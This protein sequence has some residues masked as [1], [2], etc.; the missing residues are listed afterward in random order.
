MTGAEVVNAWFTPFHYF[1]YLGTLAVVL[2]AYLQWKWSRTCDKNI[3][4]VIVKEAGGTETLLVPKQGGSV[5]IDNPYTG[6]PRLWA[7]S[8][9]ATIPMP[10][11]G[12]G[13]LPRFLLKT[14]QQAIFLEGDWEPL[15]NRSPHR[16]K[17]VSPDV[18]K[19]LLDIKEHATGETA[20]AIEA[21]LDGISTAPTREMIASPAMLGNLIHEKISALVITVTKDFTDPIYEAIKKMGR[22]IDPRIV[23]IGLGLLGILLVVN[24]FYVINMEGG[25][26]G[27][28]IEDMKAIKQA[29]GVK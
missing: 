13:L 25:E 9:L 6:T 29:L 14:I 7:I 17:V 8:E 24:L 4:V 20:E 26:L 27:T 12:I 3:E 5:S 15:L 19:T 11:P 22:R 21:L 2:I 18:A 16:Q 1:V 28:V 10:Y 23:Y